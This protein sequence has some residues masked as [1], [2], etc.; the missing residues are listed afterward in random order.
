MKF[1]ALVLLIHVVRAEHTPRHMA[2]AHRC[3][4]TG[5]AA[6]TNCGTF[7]ITKTADHYRI[8]AESV[9][10]ERIIDHDFINCNAVCTFC[11]RI[12]GKL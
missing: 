1:L 9:S 3:T 2:R 5:D 12:L 4:S 7:R 6:L 8:K 10:G 11:D